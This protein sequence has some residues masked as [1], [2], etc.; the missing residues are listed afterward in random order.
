M[1]RYVATRLFQQLSYLTKDSSLQSMDV[2]GKKVDTV[3]GI[4][5]RR[6][7]AMSADEALVA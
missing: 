3:F 7:D 6:V 1:S 2:G 5:L 4:P